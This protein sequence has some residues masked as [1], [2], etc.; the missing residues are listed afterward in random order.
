MVWYYRPAIIG[1][2]SSLRPAMGISAEANIS[3]FDITGK[4]FQQKFFKAKEGKNIFSLDFK[5]A[6]PGIYLV[7]LKIGG[8]SV[9]RKVIIN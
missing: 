1:C 9:S 7:N 8:G 4:K 5:N 6:L 3:I 2:A